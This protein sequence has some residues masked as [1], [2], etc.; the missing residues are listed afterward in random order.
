MTTVPAR[1]R[2]PVAGPVRRPAAVTRRAGAGRRVPAVVLRV[3][4]ETAGALLVL[5][6]VAL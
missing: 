2:R 6:A 1:R 4:G 3:A 5:A